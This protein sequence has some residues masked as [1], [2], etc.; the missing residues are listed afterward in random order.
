MRAAGVLV[1]A[2]AVL[3]VGGCTSGPIDDPT[4]D[5]A[6]TSETGTVQP[7]STPASPSPTPTPKPS[8]E[9]A[10]G[11]GTVTVD[12]TEIPVRGDCDL[13]KDFGQQPI[14]GLDDEGVDVLLA[15]DN[16][17]GEGEHVGPFAVAVRLLGSGP[18]EGRTITSVGR[19]EEGSSDLTVTWEG[20]VETA[21]LRDRQER[22]FLDVATLHLEATQQRVEGGGSRELVVDVTCPISRPG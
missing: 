1:T 9:M 12:G 15:V 21:E 14:R 22:E 11:A 13:S 4:T 16:L 2:V 18:V 8:A 17:T 7:P 6:P 3:L 10:L 19:G 20:E 5:P